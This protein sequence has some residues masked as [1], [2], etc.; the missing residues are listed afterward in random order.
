MSYVQGDGVG[1]Q[2]KPT[3]N[4]NYP[5][6]QDV[7]EKDVSASSSIPPSSNHLQNMADMV[8][9][10]RRIELRKYQQLQEATLIAELERLQSRQKENLHLS[11][12][13]GFEPTLTSQGY[14][15]Q[16][17]VSMGQGHQSI[18]GQGQVF[19]NR[20]EKRQSEGFT[21]T[22]SLGF[23]AVD[24][25]PSAFKPIPV[26]ASQ[27]SNANSGLYGS[28]DL[29]SDNGHLGR[30]SSITG[31]QPYLEIPSSQALPPSSW[32][33]EV[34][35]QQ[36]Q[37]QALQAIK[38]L[39]PGNHGNNGQGQGQVEQLK[40]LSDIVDG[41][42]GHTTNKTNS[43]GFSHDTEYARVP[44]PVTESQG[45]GQ[46]KGQ[47]QINLVRKDDDIEVTKENGLYQI[48]RANDRQGEIS[49][50]NSDRSVISSKQDNF[51]QDIPE[52]DLPRVEQQGIPVSVN[53]VT[54]EGKE[55]VSSQKDGSENLSDVSTPRN[56]NSS[57]ASTGVS[58]P[59]R[60][61]FIPNN[62]SGS[63]N[64]IGYIPGIP[65][66]TGLNQ[67]INLPV[68]HELAP[69]GSVLSAVTG[70]NQGQATMQTTSQVT[71]QN[72]SGS[73]YHSNSQAN[74]IAAGDIGV[75]K[76]RYL[77]KELKECNKVTSKIVVD[78]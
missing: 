51:P 58:Q 76:L 37:Q 46:G 3:G 43:T 5:D 49:D 23:A 12:E 28:L 73:S 67:P 63:Q 68:T 60:V 2:A 52:K 4:G 41:D 77:L 26:D 40:L 7:P 62:N 57:G 56:Q 54:S 15:D 71:S 20:E 44:R 16:R 64:V 17:S 21:G 35:K 42:K 65:I 55:T 27:L 61:V 53:S 8:D 75:R 24:S 70:A 39:D 25:V 11:H 29:D 32:L 78:L 19:S 31:F 74:N 69:D 72:I 59:G 1:T 22:G 48:H 30:G 50:Q 38:D 18:A 6:T 9:M 66:A 33:T 36:L 13:T 45:Q 47:S 10:Y 14:T 34:Q